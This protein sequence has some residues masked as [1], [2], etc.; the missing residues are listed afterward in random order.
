MN[1]YSL[2]RVDADGDRIQKTVIARSLSE[3]ESVDLFKISTITKFPDGEESIRFIP[4]AIAQA[5]TDSNIRRIERRLEN[6]NLN[7]SCQ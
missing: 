1:V 3:I 4:A 7:K 2:Y 5:A 6:F